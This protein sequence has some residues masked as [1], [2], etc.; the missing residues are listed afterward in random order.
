MPMKPGLHSLLVPAFC[1]LLG[2]TACSPATDGNKE[3][4]SATP[5]S[6]NERPLPP[7]WHEVEGR[8]LTV[9]LPYR[10]SSW[11]LWAADD[12]NEGPFTFKSLDNLPGAGPQGTDLAVFIY[13]ADG[14]GSAS[15]KFGLNT[16]TRD[17]PTPP[18][19]MRSGQSKAYY[20]ANVEVE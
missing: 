11:Y 16:V 9:N 20:V 19:Q 15:I 5:T 10:A 18:E 4:N 8:K 2:L 7:P 1:T 17:G 14:P 6:D 3:G 12:E 13:E